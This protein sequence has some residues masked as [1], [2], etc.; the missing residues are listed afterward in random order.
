MPAHWVIFGWPFTF[1]DAKVMLEL[2]AMNISNLQLLAIYL[3]VAGVTYIAEAAAIHWYYRYTGNHY[4]KHHFTVGK[5]FI[6]LTFPLYMFTIS[7]YHY[8]YS[9]VKM[10][11]LSAVVGTALEWLVGYAFHRIMGFRLW[12]YHAYSISKYTSLLSIPL[13]GFAG[14]FVPIIGKGCGLIKLA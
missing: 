4:K 2:T 6:F 7:I 12:S 5:F 9:P 10:F 11:M 13:W 3:I 1:L 14:G 8:G